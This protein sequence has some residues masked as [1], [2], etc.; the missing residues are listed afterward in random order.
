MMYEENKV[1]QRLLL[2]LVLMLVLSLQALPTLGQ[3]AP[4]SILTL[5]EQIAGGRDVTISVSNMPSADQA[6]LRA[7]WEAQAARFTALYPNV[8][9]EGNEIQYDP[10]TFT[11]LAA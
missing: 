7:A 11:A 3:D 6:D 10:A 5:P 2:V 1:K 9:I 4:P 8:H